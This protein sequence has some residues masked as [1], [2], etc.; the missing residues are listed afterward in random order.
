MGQ[1]LAAYGADGAILAFYDTIDSPAPDGV[2]VIEITAD[3][4]DDLM[5]AQASG[6]RLAIKDGVPVAIDPPPLSRAELANVK[7]A[8]RDM[9]LK[10]TDW[11][12][13]RHQDEKL[14]GDGTTLTA[15]QFEALIKYRQA[16]RDI[17]NADRWPDVA[18][19]AVPDFLTPVA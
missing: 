10:S 11:L 15:S 17:S 7:R 19:P 9:A 1:K 14:I 13:S 4:L 3:Q 18:L 5:R 16:L 12:V 2:P 8:Q 6:K